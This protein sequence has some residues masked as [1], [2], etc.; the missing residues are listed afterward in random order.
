MPTDEINAVAERAAAAQSSRWATDHRL[1]C[2]LMHAWANRLESEADSLATQLIEETGKIQREAKAEVAA[3]IDSVRFNA[4]LCRLPTGRATSLYDGSHSHL[5]R[6]PVGP[7]IFIAPWNWPVLLL[8]RDLAPGFAAGVTAIVKPATQT[9]RITKR[10][11]ELAHE[12]GIPKDALQCVSGSR[13]TASQF[14]KHPLTAAVAITGSTMAGQ[15]VMRDAAETLTRPLL[16]LGGKASLL[17]LPDGDHKTALST[18]ARASI[19]TAGQMCMACT[20]VLVHQ[21]KLAEARAILSSLLG[22]MRPGHP[23][24]P[25]TDLGP[26]ISEDAFEKVTG[27]VDTARNSAEIITGGQQVQPENTSGYFL[28]PTLVTSVDPSSPLVQD[29]IF[30]PVLTLETYRNE[31]DAVALAN[32]S[33]FGLAAAIYGSDAGRA[34]TLARSV[35]AGTVWV[36]SYQKS[37]AEAPSGGYKMSGMGRT[38]GIEGMEEFTEL[39]HIVIPGE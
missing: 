18:A 35:K 7:T 21:D 17:V 11:I 3:A 9:Y 4:G 38:R 23:E 36:N 10:L 2:D 39:K 24:D 33:P 16:E 26:L 13:K 5:V 34:M 32:A 8:L 15:S 19:T 22:S 31:D 25:N 6:E 12:T 30:G 20:R 28:E 37:Y 14:I 29:D 1:R 27:Y